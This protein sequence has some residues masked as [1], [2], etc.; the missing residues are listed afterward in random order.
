MQENLTQNSPLYVDLDGTFIKSDMLF[1]SLLV[2]L[3]SNPLLFFSCFWWLIK[4]KSYLKY[5]LSQR[6]N[7]ETS[8]LPVNEDFYE[9]L[10]AEK[11]NKRRIILATASNEKYAGK[12]CE[13][14]PVFDEYIASNEKV[15]LKG[16]AKLDKINTLSKKFSYAGNAIEDFILFE[17]ADE[18]YLVNPSRKVKKKSTNLSFARIFDVDKRPLKT[19]LKQLRVHQWLKNFLIF[20]PL[21]VTHGFSNFN[22]M[23]LSFL[24]FISFSFLA[25]ATYIVNDLLDLESDRAHQYKKSRPLAAG[26]ISIPAA[27]VVALILFTL[28]FVIALAIPGIF[29]GVIIGYLCLTLLYSFKIKKYIAMDVIVLACLYTIRIIAGAAILSVPVSFWLLSFSM[30][31]FFSL[32]LVKRCAELKSLEEQALK[33]AKGRD[34]NIN[35]YIVLMSMGTSSALLSVLMFSFYI[36]NNILTNQYQQPTILWLIIP[37]LC[38]WLMRMWVSTH[39]GKMHDDPIVFSIKDRGSL[40]TVSFI[41]VITILAQVL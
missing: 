28:S 34:Y 38:Y 14:Y 10:L 2:V 30:F 8:L 24:G 39:R 23:T 27:K 36:N 21:L 6:A 19:W 1:E 12:I 7:I 41:V 35:D 3:K 5:Q 17:K 22:S 18:S 9:F 33:N 11:A 13:N 37:A 32:A 4:G 40:L 31:V 15:N 29:I 25:S 20:V 16:Q 26:L